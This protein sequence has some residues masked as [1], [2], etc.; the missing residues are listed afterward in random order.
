MRFANKNMLEWTRTQKRNSVAIFV[1]QEACNCNEKCLHSSEFFT[2]F[3]LSRSQ[4]RNEFI[5][6]VK[7][8]RSILCPLQVF[9][10][11]CVLVGIAFLL[12]ALDL[13]FPHGCVLANNNADGDVSQKMFKLHQN[14]G[15]LS[16]LLGNR[17]SGIG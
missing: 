1:Y 4:A 3:E 9:N 7:S 10:N 5:M 11:L 8:L 17:D 12:G 15:Q 6:R 2:I 16:T 13:L 14:E